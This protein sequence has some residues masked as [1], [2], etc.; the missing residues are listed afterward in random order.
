MRVKGIDVSKN[1][2]TIDWEKVKAAGVEFAMIRVGYRGYKS[3][4][5]NLDPYFVANIEGALSNGIAVGP[6]FFSTA[7]SKAESAEEAEFVYEQ[8]KPYDVTLPAVFDYEG[9]NKINYRSFGV[10]K[11][12]R[13]A[14]CK[15]FQEVMK[16]HGYSCMLYGS[17]GHIRSK[18]DLSQFD[19]YLWVARYPS[20]TKVLDDEKYFPNVPGYNDR[21][22]IWQCAECA[23]IDGISGKVD[24]DYM[25]IDVRKGKFEEKQEEV[26]MI[27]PV[28]YK[29]TDVRWKTNSYAVDGERST[30][31]SAGCGPTAL[32]DCLAAIVSPY[33]DPL[34]LAAWS[35]DHNYKVKNSGTSYNFFVP[36]AAD[37]GVKV[38]R[39]NTSNV[40]GK[41]NDTVHAQVL[42]ELRAG[43]WIIACMGKGIWT[44]S[45]HYV[46]AY[47][48]QGGNVYIND[49]ASNKASR[50]C[51]KWLTFISQVKYYWVVE[52]PD[53][54]KKAGIVQDGDYRQADFV[55]EVQMTCGA[56]IDGIAGKQTLNKTVTVSKKKNRKHNVVLPLQKAL[57]KKNHYHGA[58][59]RIAGNQFE[60]AV[61][62]YQKWILDYEEQD[63]EVTAKGKMWKSLLGML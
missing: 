15:A 7:V 55:R 18:Y 40:Y 19:D 36:C 42:A 10:T 56:G 44:S 43:N 38:R 24:L 4:K 34:T 1:Q 25:Y 54:V 53:Y 39:L 22:A 5:I 57:K 59:D 45:G 6:Y 16:A 17:K 35:R 51:N 48:Y 49:P 2:K 23:R 21:I 28:D 61:N 37:Y 32:A 8:I 33:I 27:K 50:V 58:L 62:S 41:I 11:E 13:T 29:Q 63:G 52:V 47:G 14:F 46:V 3:G 60:E 31:G 12:Q 30:I 26:K 9:Y 20:K